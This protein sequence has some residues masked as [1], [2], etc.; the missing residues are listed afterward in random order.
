M[1]KQRAGFVPR[2]YRSHAL[3]SVVGVHSVSKENASAKQSEKSRRN[4][5]THPYATLRAADHTRSA[6]VH[7]LI[8][9]RKKGFIRATMRGIEGCASSCASVAVMAQ[10]QV[11]R[12]EPQRPSRQSRAALRAK[13]LTRAFSS[14]SLPALDAGWIPVRVKKT[15]QNKR[16]EPPFR[17][18]RNGK[19]SSGCHLV[20]APGKHHSADDCC[21]FGQSE[22]PSPCC[23]CS[24]LIFYKTRQSTHVWRIERSQI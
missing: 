13:M 22:W 5:R 15:R 8:S 1:L 23:F 18:N 21:R 6:L 11:E 3:F 16:L 19:G 24:P 14:E 12:G 9:R 7:H 17:F 20:E 2:F 10:C 4:H